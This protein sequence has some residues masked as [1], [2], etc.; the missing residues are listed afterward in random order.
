MIAGAG[1]GDLEFLS[2]FSGAL[3]DAAGSADHAAKTVRKAAAAFV[4]QEGP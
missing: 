2:R 3:Y 4:R 1:N